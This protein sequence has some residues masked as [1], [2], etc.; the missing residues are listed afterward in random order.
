MSSV[1]TQPGGSGRKKSSPLNS[2]DKDE[3]LR[4]DRCDC[5]R[6]RLERTLS[7]SS[8]LRRFS[9]ML[10]LSSNFGRM[11]A[12]YPSVDGCSD[13]TNKAPLKHFKLCFDKIRGMI[14]VVKQNKKSVFYIY[15][16][17]WP[18]RTYVINGVYKANVQ[19]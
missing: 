5:E 17:I 1:I 9:V 6:V 2:S 4:Q 16:N 7:K 11:T 19:Q 8:L 3:E 12:I 13:L 14:V 10:L 15:A 18:K